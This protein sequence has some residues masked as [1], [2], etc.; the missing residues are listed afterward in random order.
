[1]AVTTNNSAVSR[2]YSTVIRN[3][4]RGLLQAIFLCALPALATA[5]ERVMPSSL[6]TADGSHSIDRHQLRSLCN[7]DLE[8]RA[9]QLRSTAMSAE[10]RALNYH[11]L[12][13]HAG[14][15]RQY[16]GGRA[17][18]RIAQK[19]LRQYWQDKR[20]ELGNKALL[21]EKGN[22]KRQYNGVDYGLTTS[23]GGLNIGFHYTF[24]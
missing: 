7:D 22:L 2:H 15:N 13:A 11:W 17:F 4:V 24:D 10:H 16:E 8:L 21:D 12:A 14:E 1:M 3:R 18:S 19:M 23:G 9:K 20:R 6:N 5:D